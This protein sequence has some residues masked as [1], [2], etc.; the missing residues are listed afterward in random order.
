M[1][2]PPAFGYAVFDQGGN[3]LYR[4]AGS[5]PVPDP[6]TGHRALTLTAALDRTANVYTL[7]NGALVV[8]P[9]SAAALALTAWQA[10][11]ATARAALD[12]SDTTMHRIAE[13]VALGLGSWTAADVVAWVTYRRALRAI[14]AASTGSAGTLPAKP[15]WPAGT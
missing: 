8:T 11:Q 4:A 6:A 15:A 5:P 7:A 10:F 2:T 12:E 1:T 9:I 13:A 14:V 3:F